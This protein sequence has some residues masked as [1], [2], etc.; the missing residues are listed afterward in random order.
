MNIADILLG[1]SEYD[2]PGRTLIDTTKD[3]LLEPDVV[4]FLKKINYLSILIFIINIA[5]IITLICLAGIP[6]IM[7]RYNDS[8]IIEL[9]TTPQGNEISVNMMSELDRYSKSQVYSLRK[10]Y[11]NRSMFKSDNYEPREE[12]FGGLQ[13]GKPWYGTEN[14][15][16]Y[17]SSK[18][19]SLRAEGES[20]F[21]NL[22]NN[23][24][25]LIGVDFPNAWDLANFDK[26]YEIC[27]DKEM[28]FIPEE[29]T[30]SKEYNMIT[31]KYKINR[32][33]ATLKYEF[34]LSGMNAR[35]LGFNYVYAFHKKNIRF[36][37]DQSAVDKQLYSL[38]D[39]LSVGNSCGIEGGCN[40]LCPMQ[41]N[42]MFYFGD[43]R[44]HE[45]HGNQAFIDF[46]L[47]KNKPSNLFSKPDMYYRIIFEK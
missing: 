13:D 45:F 5:M 11:V 15:I 2:E 35:D 36:K 38:P 37:N 1:K 34:M 46:K 19:A 29:I 23:P 44:Y 20:F 33:I 14:L 6:Y 26:S 27:S 28:L 17:D 12:V 47:W 10:K 7:Y 16:C 40:N 9:N 43:E 21:S 22:I 24:S 32:R 3:N 18:P 41:H 31:V 8:A 4:Q 30:Y 25:I 39:Y 42:M